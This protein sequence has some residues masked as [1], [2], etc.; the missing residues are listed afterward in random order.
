[1]QVFFKAFL[2]K[3]LCTANIAEVALSASIPVN[4]TRHK[5]FW[6]FILEGEARGQSA[7]SFVDDFEVAEGNDLT[8]SSNQFVFRFP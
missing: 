6:D 5:R 7:S 8:K 2:P 4:D 3:S 1:M